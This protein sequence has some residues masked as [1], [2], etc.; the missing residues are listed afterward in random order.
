MTEQ[1]FREIYPPEVIELMLQRQEEQG[2]PRSI[3][4]FLEDIRAGKTRLVRYT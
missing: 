1:E 4:P 3:K 2:N